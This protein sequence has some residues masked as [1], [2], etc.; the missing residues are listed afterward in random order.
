[1][2]KIK[3]ILDTKNI[4]EKILFL[5]EV[6]KK[7][8][9]F[10]LAHLEFELSLMQLL[11]FYR[12]SHLHKKG[13]SVAAILRH[14]E[15]FGLDFYVNKNV[16]I[17]RPDTEIMVE[18]ILSKIMAKDTLVD[19]GT[20]S[21][22]I[23]ISVLKNREI[24]NSF[25]TDISV[26]ALRVAKKNAR[27]HKVFPKFLHGNLLNTFCRQVKKGQIRLT[28][29][30][31]ITAN[32]PYL[33]QKQFD[34]EPSIQREPHLALVANNDGLE[35]YEKLLEQLRGIVHTAVPTCH[36][37]QR[38]GISLPPEQTQT[39]NKK[40]VHLFLEI[41][42]TQNQKIKKIVQTFFPAAQ[43]EI[44]KDLSGLERVVNIKM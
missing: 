36:P 29:N 8:K 26:R 40:S 20:G 15:F 18:E 7:D 19:V 13:Y 14:K 22:C 23:L 31:F 44:K 10:V 16:L 34:T 27:T 24:P 43:V 9:A 3:D 25:G 2:L 11:R 28:G 33:T 21:G 12:Y 42:P 1:M 6:I 35:L 41:D 5:A 4:Q 38:G 32:L 17:P 37:D 39:T 30:I